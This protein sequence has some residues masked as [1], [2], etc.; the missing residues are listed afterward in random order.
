MLR[1]FDSR[2]RSVL[3]T[4]ASEWAIS[5]ILTQPD[6]TEVHHPV[7]YES[8]KLTEA[9]QAYPAY[10]LELLAVVHALRMF[11]HYLLGSAVARRDPPA[12][13]PTSPFRPIIKR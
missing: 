9:E 2:R 6:D 3:T 7:A 13:C 11:R 12:S 4:D 10:V 1:T 8:R 5:A